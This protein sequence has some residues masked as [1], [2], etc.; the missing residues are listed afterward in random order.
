MKEIE[1]KFLVVSDAWTADAGPG[2]LILQ[3]Y[4][5]AE[6]GN[7]VRVRILGDGSATLTVKTGGSAM[8]RDE[9]EYPVP[10]SDARR[11][12]DQSVGELIEKTRHLVPFGQFIWEVDVYHGRLG[13][14][15]VAEVE[16]ASEDD[17]PEIPPWCGREVTDDRNYSNAALARGG[18]PAEAS[19][20]GIPD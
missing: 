5:A 9:F 12:M 11:M 7:S 2:R 3:S 1:R 16:M 8:V 15:V 10:V 14:L 18:Q 6:N 19:H 17:R 4:V 13:G 20:G